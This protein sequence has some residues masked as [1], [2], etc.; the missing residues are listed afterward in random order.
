MPLRLFPGIDWM[1]ILYVF[2]ITMQENHLY[3]AF[4]NAHIDFG[5]TFAAHVSKYRT[6]NQKLF[7]VCFAEICEV[8]KAPRVCHSDSV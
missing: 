5:Y 7:L 3:C 8:V 2:Y 1:D 4:I 6:E